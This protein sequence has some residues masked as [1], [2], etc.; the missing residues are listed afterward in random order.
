MSYISYSDVIL[1]KSDIY[2]CIIDGCMKRSVYL[3][4]L[5][6][7]FAACSSGE[8]EFTPLVTEVVMLSE[9]EKFAPGEDV[10]VN[11]LGF[12]SGDE[13]M[14]DI[15]WQ[16]GSGEFAPEGY[17]KGVWGIVTTC[18]PSSI[19]F[20]APGHYPASKVE[21]WLRRAGRMMSLG[22]ISV[23]DG[24][25]PATFQLYGITNS[26][27]NTAP[28]IERIDRTTGET[29][30]IADFTLGDLKCA[31]NAPG[32]NRI[33]GLSDGLGVFFDLSMRYWR[34]S[35]PLKY[36]AVG[37]FS[38]DVAY[39]R[40]DANRLYLDDMSL[41]RTL[42]EV[43][44]MWILPD[45]LTADMLAGT[46]FVLA[47]ENKL[48][49]AADNGDGTFLP[50]VLFSRIG[51]YRV[52][53][54]DPVQ[55]SALIP[56]NVIRSREENGEVKKYLVGGYVISAADGVASQL[57]LFNTQTCTFDQPFA[58]VVDP[59]RSIAVDLN[60]TAQNIY[61]LLGDDPNGG[62]IQCYSQTD[63]RWHSLG[64]RYPYSEIVLAR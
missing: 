2:I 61:L 8:D 7:L 46:S 43:A 28:G 19:T 4:L 45:G 57:R 23:L 10:T 30:R 31:V 21:V 13:I 24:L 26:D 32:S 37:S 1:S 62:S 9:S 42:P 17:A 15:Y 6:T 34:D 20:L 53:V 36:V 12:E 33:Y 22:T 14:L 63:G 50:V 25:S 56:F 52:C 16:E 49:L 44:P 5:G 59:V 54:G 3:L 35:D 11:A 60:G 41:T 29:A 40:A 18:T 38:S 39:L 47:D 64:E 51:G 27:N 48:L 55:A 58:T